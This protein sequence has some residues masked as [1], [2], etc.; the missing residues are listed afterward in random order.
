M[1]SR[2]LAVALTVILLINTGCSRGPKGIARDPVTR[3][4]GTILIDG[5]PEQM[6]AVQLARLGEPDSKAGTSKVLT[7]SAFT[8]AEG[9]FSIG[10]YEGGSNG[11][12]APKGE[13]AL[14]I[15]WGE[16]NLIGGLYSGDKFKG[17][18]ADPAKSEFKVTVA[19]KPVDLGELELKTN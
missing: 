8:N 6:V 17:K 16:L 18:Y 7:P 15:Q 2:N 5:K 1:C 12:G 19:E 10:T 14:T 4:S 13:Y 9:K 11:D 3:V